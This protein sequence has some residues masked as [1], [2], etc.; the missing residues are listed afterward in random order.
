MKAKT[1]KAAAAEAKK[2]PS[3]EAEKGVE[4]VH[5]ATA[6]FATAAAPGVSEQ[7]HRD[8]ISRRFFTAADGKL[9]ISIITPRGLMGSE[10]EER[11]ANE[12]DKRH[13]PA[14]Y[15]AYLAAL[16]D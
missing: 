7:G 10:I 8:F 4:S 14:A 11:P 5:T 3:I 15:A 1:K 9:W 16:S 6:N 13:F 2:T 12:T